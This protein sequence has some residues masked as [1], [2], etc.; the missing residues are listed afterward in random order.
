MYKTEIIKCT[1][2]IEERA[3]KIEDKINELEAKNYQFVSIC[4]TPNF[5]AILLFKDKN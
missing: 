1:R 4:S 5:G 3:K 2:N